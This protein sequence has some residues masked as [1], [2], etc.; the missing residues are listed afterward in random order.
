MSR[1]SARPLVI[2]VVVA[3][4]ASCAITVS[5]KDVYGIYVASY[6]FGIETMTLN[7]DGTFVQSIEIK[8]AE[9][10]TVRGRWEFDPKESRV[11]FHGAMMVAD[12]FDAPRPDWRTPT[13]GLVSLDVEKHWFRIVIGSAST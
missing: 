9:P 5:A 10:T 13:L 6:P 11:T 7:P 8:Q 2:I 12:R 4:L 1:I 3:M